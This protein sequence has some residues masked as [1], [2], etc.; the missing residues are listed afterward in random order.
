MNGLKLFRLKLETVSPLL[1]GQVRISH[2]IYETLN[3]IPSSTLKGALGTHFMDNHCTKEKDSFGKCKRCDVK[4]DCL[5]YKFY[6]DYFYSITPGI[7]TND[8]KTT[9]SCKDHDII[10]SHTLMMACK[11]C[12]AKEKFLIQ[13]RLKKWIKMDY[14]YTS[15]EICKYKTTM[16][17]INSY[18]CRN[19]KI[20]FKKPSKNSTIS[21]SINRAKMSSLTGHLFHYNYIESGN[22][23]ESY[24][25]LG[26][27]DEI[28]NE[29]QKINDIKL[30][31]AKS[32]GFGKVLLKI[33]ELSLTEKVSKNIKIIKDTLLKE[34]VLIIA[35]KTNIFSLKFD[36]SK[37]DLGF[38]S[39]PTI[40]LNMAINRVN[41][42]L[43]LGLQNLNESD[44][45]LI[46]SLGSTELKSAWSFKTDQPKPHIFAATP[47]SLYKFNVKTESIDE[48]LLKAL[49][50][51]E[52][53]GLDDYSKLGYNLIYYPSFE[54]E[55]SNGFDKSN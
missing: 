52:F 23:F 5:F 25:V 37:N 42:I 16:Q 47:G 40:D 31:R 19:C 43:N 1:V 30:G 55:F 24:I 22:I 38:L 54:E 8:L 53:I 46:N 17:P 28:V 44:F 35:A 13:N 21:T 6:Y 33:E 4:Q 9:F 20:I 11:V 32:R 29:L 3:Y 49:G 12:K 36:I 2:N 10:P 41:N 15:C 27:N 39:D 14:F 34:K 48:N 51:L 26:K 50:Y 7:F 18:F 45:Q